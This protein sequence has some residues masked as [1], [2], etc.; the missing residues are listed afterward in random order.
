MTF[1]EVFNQIKDSMQDIDVSQV[2]EHLAYQFNI[3]GE[4]SGIFYAEVKDGTLTVEPYEYHDRDVIFTCA[5]ETLIN[6]ISGKRDPLQAVAL[7][8]LKVEGDIEKARYIKE[9]LESRSKK[10]A[11]KATAKKTTTTKKAATKKTAKK[12]TDTK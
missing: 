2:T 6:I 3:T 9:V 1:E 12:K 7:M 5:A 4:G 10:P 8:K 11:K